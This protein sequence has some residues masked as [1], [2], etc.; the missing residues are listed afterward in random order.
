MEQQFEQVAPHHQTPQEKALELRERYQGRFAFGGESAGI[1]TP[2]CADYASP[3][4]R[5]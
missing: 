5:S 1:R 4:K 2:G 3:A